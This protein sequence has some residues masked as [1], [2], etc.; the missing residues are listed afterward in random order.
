[1]TKLAKILNE[2]GMS[3]RDLQRAIFAKFGIK[4]GDDRI[5]KMTTGKLKNYNLKTALMISESLDVT[6]ND[7]I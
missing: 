4:I 7:I 6:L 5:S 3:Q 1:M 2:R